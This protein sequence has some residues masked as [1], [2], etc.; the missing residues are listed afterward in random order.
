MPVD[1]P[2]SYLNALT[3]LLVNNSASHQHSSAGHRPL[4]ADNCLA[5][6]NDNG[7]GAVCSPST[8]VNTDIRRQLLPT[9]ATA[10]AAAATDRLHSPPLTPRR[11]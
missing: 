4:Y 10:A 7:G 2:L 8:A 11:E 3:I 6:A 5:A 1:R 9:A